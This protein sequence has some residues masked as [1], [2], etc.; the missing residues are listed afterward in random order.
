M[1]YKVKEIKLQ[2]KV[3]NTFL[4]LKIYSKYLLDSM[5]KHERSISNDYLYLSV[6]NRDFLLYLFIWYSI[7]F[8]LVC[9]TFVLKKKRKN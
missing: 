9:V 5:K 7:N 2:N 6:G 1:K 8:Q 4:I 3:Y